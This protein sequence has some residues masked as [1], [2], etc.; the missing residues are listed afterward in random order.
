[1]LMPTACLQMVLNKTSPTTYTCAFMC[2]VETAK[3][4]SQSDER[5]NK[6]GTCDHLRTTDEGQ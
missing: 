6:R 3:A 1:M 2:K 5:K 4:Q